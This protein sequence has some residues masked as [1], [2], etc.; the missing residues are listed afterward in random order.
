MTREE[1]Q[2]EFWH[3]ARGTTQSTANQLAARSQSGGYQD[4]RKVAEQ[5]AQK[6][7]VDHKKKRFRRELNYAGKKNQGTNTP[8]NDIEDDI[9]D[10]VNKIAWKH[11]KKRV[12]RNA[13]KWIKE[14]II[15][16][17]KLPKNTYT[18]LTTITSVH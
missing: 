1:I 13:K 18:R 17:N 9:D 16:D 11:T 10:K 7:F 6:G 15:G 12:K 2:Q 4:S 14:N 3:S 8:V 5:Y